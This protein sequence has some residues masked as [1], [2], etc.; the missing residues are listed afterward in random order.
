MI[1]TVK[2]SLL[3][4]RKFNQ[5]FHTALCTLNQFFCWEEFYFLL[6]CCMRQQVDKGTGESKDAF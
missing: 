1:Q 2:Y 3:K 6:S 4:D 5:G